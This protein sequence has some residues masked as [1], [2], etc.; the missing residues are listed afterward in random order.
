MVI[1]NVQVVQPLIDAM[2]DP[3]PDV[4]AAA[5][6]ALEKVKSPASVEA[7][8]SSLTSS[9]DEVRRQA[10]VSLGE[11]RNQRFLKHFNKMLSDP[12]A[13]VRIA[14]ASIDPTGA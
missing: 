10:V 8:E 5:S 13:K 7:F 1:D 4:R 9:N 11:F 6:K 14:A 3:D 12:D 2:K